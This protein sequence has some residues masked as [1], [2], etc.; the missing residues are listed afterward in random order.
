MVTLELKC[1]AD[2]G[3]LGYPNVGKSTF[4]A[5]VTNARPK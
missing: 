3:L 1:I 5:A 2:V 4:L